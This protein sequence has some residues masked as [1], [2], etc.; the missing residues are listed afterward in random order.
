MARNLPVIIVFNEK[1]LKLLFYNVELRANVKLYVN[2]ELCGAATS[3][4][5]KK[6]YF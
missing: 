1:L 4:G 2:V 3:N 6:T 5:F